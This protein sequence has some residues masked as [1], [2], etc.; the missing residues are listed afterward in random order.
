VY[1]HKTLACVC[2]AKS[3]LKDREDD[4]EYLLQRFEVFMAML[5]KIHV[6]QDVAVTG[7]V[8]P[9]TLK[10][11]EC[12]SL[13]E[14]S[15]SRYRIF[16]FYYLTLRWRHYAPCKCQEPLRQQHITSQKSSILGI[17]FLYISQ[18]QSS[19]S[20]WRDWEITTKNLR[21]AKTGSW[22]FQNKRQK[23]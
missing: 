6:F 4:K 5:L 18:I 21:T 15:S 13:Q 20:L 1:R 22:N 7:E 8:A 17:Y 3:S 11:T 16:F 10:K 19:V 14:S 23:C 2:L 9:D 12:L